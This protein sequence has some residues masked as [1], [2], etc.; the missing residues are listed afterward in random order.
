MGESLRDLRKASEKTLAEV[1]KALHVSVRTVARYEDG[2]RRINIDQVIPLARL[3]RV[4]AEDI[5]AAQ[6]ISVAVRKSE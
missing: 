4:S 2:T 6:A 1:A 3:Y 5:I